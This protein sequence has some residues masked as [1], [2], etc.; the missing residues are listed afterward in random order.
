L[1][2]HTIETTVFQKVFE[3]A[4]VEVFSIPL[5]HRTLC[6]GWLFK[7]KQRP[8]NMRPEQ[9]EKY[10]VPFPEI[11]AIKSG[12]DFTLPDG[13]VIPNSELTLPPVPPRSF[14]FCSDT[15]PSPDIIAAVR[16]V[17]CLYHEATFTNDHLAEAEYSGH[18][19]AEQAAI[20]AR[21][22]GVG[23]LLMGHF[24]ARY[25]ETTQHLEEARAVFQYCNVVEEG[26]AY[27]I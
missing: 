24:S 16:G 19:T 15:A 18:S 25:K 27:E 2:I 10:N 5:N 9:I 8:A 21:E 17:N 20:V 3:N 26:R 1:H 11:P 6:A 4:K 22:A 14:A 7:E 23:Q 13:T 12:G